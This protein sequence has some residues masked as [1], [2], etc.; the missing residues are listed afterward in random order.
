VS[1]D[2]S[3]IV[4]NRGGGDAVI[5]DA[6]NGTRSIAD[7]LSSLGVVE[8][9]GWTLYASTISGDG[10]TIVGEGVNPDGRREAWLARLRPVPEP[11]TIALTVLALLTLV[12]SRRKHTGLAPAGPA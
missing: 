12:A 2:G 9:A 6:S 1:A 10:T 8:H 7:V 11:S 3:T 4:G 5:W